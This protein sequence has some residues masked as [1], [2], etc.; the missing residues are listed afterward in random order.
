MQ[1]TKPTPV[2]LVMGQNYTA[3]VAGPYK[4]KFNF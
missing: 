3:F 1:V 2:G 4:C